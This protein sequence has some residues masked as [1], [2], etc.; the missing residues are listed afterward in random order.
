M[1]DGMRDEQLRERLRQA[2]MWRLRTQD[3]ELS[4]ADRAAFEAWLAA[5][6]DNESLY[7]QAE[8]FWQALGEISP[9]DLRPEVAAMSLREKMNLG[10]SAVFK[11]LSRPKVW[12]AGAAVGAAALLVTVLTAPVQEGISHP[13]GATL[14]ADARASIATDIGETRTLVLV[15]GTRVTL[16]A[17][18]R[19]ETDFD[20]LSR[21]VT[22]QGGA[23]Y[24]DVAPDKS[25]PFRV[26]AGEL[27]ATALGTIFDVRANGGVFRVAVAE[28]AVDVSY[29]FKVFGRPTGMVSN[30]V[31]QP[32]QKIVA[33]TQQGLEAPQSL[34]I[35]EVGA[36]RSDRLVYDGSPVSEFIADAN[37]YSRRPIKV[38]DG[39]E[40]ILE[41]RLRGAFNAQDID[42]MLNALSVIHPIAIDR[43]QDAV[44][45]L[46]LR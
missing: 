11:G 3:P 18:S 32:G 38:A 25:R 43:S 6:P 44:I 2:H 23:A 27:K 1:M 12:G 15:D 22:L 33:L 42:G 19:I 7:D 5:H 39:S 14:V 45:S 9:E 46:S 37:R 41:L 21:R 36:W 29:P 40:A 28:G 20:T 35:E 17:G 26:S 4:H 30:K 10:L 34:A 31:L 24:F 8:T 13:E 16:G